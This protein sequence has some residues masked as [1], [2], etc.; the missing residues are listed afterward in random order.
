MAAETPA[1]PLEKAV[2]EARK[3][4]GEYEK[5]G[6]PAVI[7]KAEIVARLLAVAKAAVEMVDAENDFHAF[8]GFTGADTAR[9]LERRF[10]A[11]AALSAAV[12]GEGKEVPRG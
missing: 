4:L 6:A 11:F 8:Y 7:V 10:A 3:A 9:V 1:A 5:D 12:R 2:E